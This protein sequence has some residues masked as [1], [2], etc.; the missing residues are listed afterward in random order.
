MKAIASKILLKVTK[1]FDNT[2]MQKVG[3]LFSVP[4]DPKL[5]Y[6]EATVI[7]VGEEVK[8]IKENDTV[9]IYPDA[10]KEFEYEGESYRV[11][12]ASEVIVVL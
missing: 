4:V 10:G 11:I 3:T 8:G 6:W 2:C 9:F 12:T 7:S 1:K 5:A